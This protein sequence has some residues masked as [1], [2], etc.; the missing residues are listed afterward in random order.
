[1][2]VDVFIF[3]TQKSG[4]TW[5]RNIL[6][7]VG[8]A[9]GRHEWQLPVLFSHIDAYVALCG[10]GKAA[11]PTIVTSIVA[12][13][14]RTALS[15]V[16]QFNI[17]KSAFPCLPE[18]ARDDTLYPHA[19][20][21]MRRTFPEAR[22]LMIVRDPRDVL[23]SSCH[24]FGLQESNL[25]EAYISSFANSWSKCNLKWILDDPDSVVRFEDL[26]EDFRGAVR[27]CL[28][29]IDLT[30]DDT[31]M[32]NLVDRYKTIEF[33]QRSDAFFYRSGEAGAWRHSLSARNA[34]IIKSV[35][36]LAMKTFDYV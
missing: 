13:A 26:K 9:S 12:N 27:Q 8:R 30:V 5:M 28:G 34:E 29:D 20:I 16:G 6:S 23:V 10:G 32:D 15:A 4:T 25:D 7:L 11:D 35:A 33:S 1:M 2:S 31:T 3:G 22:T 36:N 19:M 17:D 24:Y 21:M 18:A 14:Y